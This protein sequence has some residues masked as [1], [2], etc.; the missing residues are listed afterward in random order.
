[1]THN[2]FV[3]MLLEYGTPFCS[4][5]N[6]L[7]VVWYG[8]KNK[9][10][11]CQQSTEKGFPVNSTHNPAVSVLRYLKMK[12]LRLFFKPSASLNLDLLVPLL[13]PRLVHG[14]Q[15][16]NL[17]KH[18][19]EKKYMFFYVYNLCRVHDF[20]R[21]RLLSIRKIEVQYQLQCS[22]RP[23][24]HPGRKSEQ[25]NIEPRSAQKLQ[26]VRP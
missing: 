12:T 13:A 11:Q 9:I 26:L 4:P 22:K 18:K 19:K 20:L 17:K 25:R 23:Y 2:C 5:T 3:F 7:F 10:F 6:L 8:A 24:N 21:T 1:M 15:I 16:Q 14:H